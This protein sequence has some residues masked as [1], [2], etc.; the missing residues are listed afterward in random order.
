MP[1]QI[2]VWAVAVALVLL[3]LGATVYRYWPGPIGQSPA[4]S[5]LPAQPY[6]RLAVSL[7][8]STGAVAIT[9]ATVIETTVKP[10]TGLGGYYAVLGGPDGALAAS[11]FAFPAEMVEEYRDA[12]GAM[13]MARDVPLAR[14]SVVVFL[15][16][17]AG[18]TS[19]RILDAVGDV[20]ASL[21]TAALGALAQTRTS[22]APGVLA[23]LLSA[24][25][26][27]LE[28]F[29]IADLQAQFPHIVFGA[30]FDDLSPVHQN[31]VAAVVPIDTLDAVSPYVTAALFDALSEL[32]ARSP[33]LLGSIASITMVEYPDASIFTPPATCS[34]EPPSP[35]QRGASKVGNQIVINIQDS[36]NGQ[37]ETVAAEVIREH[38]A[39]EA[40]HA[41]HKLMDHATNVVEERLPPDVVTHV[42]D[43]RDNLGHMDG[44]LSSTWG[45]LQ[46][47]AQ[48]AY[49]G[50]GSYEGSNWQCAYPG[51][52][53]ATEAGFKRGYGSAS[54]FE[55]VATH[56]EMFYDDTSSFTTHPV[57]QQFAGLT[58]EVPRPQLLAFAKLNFLRGLEL[59]GEADYQACVQNADPADEDGF[60]LAD[61]NYRLGLKAGSINLE[62]NIITGEEGSR[63]AVLGKA[64]AGQAMLQIFARPPYYS[65][66]GFHRLDNTLGWLTPYEGFAYRKQNGKKPKSFRRRNLITW[67]PAEYDGNIELTRKTRISS[68][69]F[70]LV[71]NNLPGYTKGYAFFVPLENWLGRQTSVQ[72][73]I[74]FRLEDN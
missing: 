7:D 45:Q 4:S 42:N 60:M 38:L 58:D 47:S 18:A 9:G 1:T 13:V 2:R 16:Y 8:A 53:G 49:S 22:G 57:C 24:I 15:P 5:A 63:W 39:H 54:V 25:D 34:G 30:S 56:V 23:R 3:A 48:V 37:L 65:P 33:T 50:Y 41:F 73:L 66:V 52:A 72:E 67:Q 46:A 35:V 68:G 6:L 31:S 64:S 74:W 59:I 51:D 69:G 20:V 11:P 10:L 28:A 43:M 61:E 26:T 36:V 14:Q 19:A 62:S 21:D 17:V 29:T 12:D 55:D 71:V 44:V 40:V 32:A 27:P 70:A